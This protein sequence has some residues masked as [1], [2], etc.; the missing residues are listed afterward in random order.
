MVK[1]LRSLWLPATLLILAGGFWAS[2]DFKGVAGG[3]ALFLFGMRS[4]EEGF[5]TFTGGTLEQLLRRS[6]DRLW[7]S[8][9]FGLVA[10]TLMQ[11]STLVSLITIAFVSSGM[12]TLAGGIGIIM[13]AN[14]GTTTGAWLIAGLGLRVDIAAY[15]M[16]FV[17]FGVVL[18]FQRT[19][20]MKGFGYLCLGVGFL[21]LGIH[22]IKE[23][24]DA[25]SGDLD[26]AA[27]AMTGFAGVLVYT[28][29]GLVATV[30][31]QSSHATLLLVI[32]ALA[33]GQIGYENA[34]AVTIGANLGS[35]TSALL[36]GVTANLGGKRLAIA[37]V[38]FNV[39]TAVLTIALIVPMVWIVEVVS[40][41]I[42]IAPGD[43]M[44]QLAVFH[45]LFNLM[46]VVLMAPFVRQLEGLLL[47]HVTISRGDVETPRYLYP[48]ALGTPDTAVSAVRSE[49]GR[50][51]ENAYGLIAHGL[52]LRRVVI[53]SEQSLSD[54]VANTRR[55]MPLD[56]DNLYE[57][58]VKSLHSSIVAFISEAQRHNLSE[59][60][61][62]ELFALRQASQDVVEAVKAMKH[63][64][65]NLLR[66]GVSGDPAIRD[67]Y[68]AMRL[69]LARLLRE[70]RQLQSESPE[71]VTGLSLDALKVEL[72]KSTHRQ[73]N[74]I[75]EQIRRRQISP[76]VATSMM[77]DEGYARAIG[78]RLIRAARSLVPPRAQAERDAETQ[79]SLD[80][81]AIA[82]LV[83]EESSGGE[84]K[85]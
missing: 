31:T 52:G 12:I 50:L 17:V 14:L 43:Y 53:E 59:G 32:I 79:L 77:N 66:Y 20:H 29:V 36:G 24:F 70:I 3:I 49:V 6:T 21:F 44:L 13:G 60:A 81:D 56:V 41:S 46:G 83:E 80:D 72:E 78:K 19:F 11:S 64:H 85:R 82:E 27:F 76:E 33:S 9:G 75:D 69:Q 30:I 15:A 28:A 2:P 73:M 38:I 26:L 25:F 55:I 63:L 51:F 48:E 42:G 23:G 61:I 47:S 8:L 34:L 39:T 4:L 74:A 84:S 7:K 1:W 71:D 62:N 18:L 35:T 54:A 45:T 37:H 22:Y 65:K 40:S 5:R 67:R 10:T 16:P 57:A 58:R 68:D